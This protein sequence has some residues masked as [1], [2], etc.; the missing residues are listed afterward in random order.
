MTEWIECICCWY[1]L[2]GFGKP[3]IESDWQLDTVEC[4]KNIQRIETLQDVFWGRF[5]ETCGKTFS[6]ND[7][8]IK[9]RDIDYSNK[10]DII[11]MLR[12]IASIVW[13]FQNINKMDMENGYFGI[14]GVITCGKRFSYDSTNGLYDPLTKTD[15]SYHPREFQMNTAFSKAYIMEESGSGKGLKGAFLFWDKNVFEKLE[16][17]VRK[18]EYSKEYNCNEYDKDEEHIFEISDKEGWIFSVFCEKNPIE[19][20]YKGIKTKIYKM[21]HS[22]TQLGTMLFG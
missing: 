7:G 17:Y 14:R 8:V 19:Y 10:H 15:I 1:D 16:E 20:D 9:N 21:T 3:F 12:F 11:G 2:L 22:R 18:S 6:L 13:D 4:E 5:S